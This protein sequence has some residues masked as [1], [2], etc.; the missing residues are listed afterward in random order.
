[1]IHHLGDW[2]LILDYEGEQ[3]LE[4]QTGGSEQFVWSPVFSIILQWKPIPEI[5]KEIR[6]D[7]DT[8][9]INVRG[10]VQEAE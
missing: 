3:V 7:K 6:R 8:D 1:M 4:T 10:T 2:E 5:R 9:E